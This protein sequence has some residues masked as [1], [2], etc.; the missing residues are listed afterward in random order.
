M[1]RLFLLLFGMVTFVAHAQVPDYVPTEGLVGWWPLDGHALDSGP[2]ALDGVLNGTSTVTNR[3][4]EMESA[5]SLD[6]ADD[7]VDFGYNDAWHLE[8]FTLNIWY[9]TL[10]WPQLGDYDAIVAAGDAYFMFV[11]DAGPGGGGNSS[12]YVST[13]PLQGGV[14]S[15]E[16]NSDGQW[17]MMTG[18]RN[19]SEESIELYIDGVYIGSAAASGGLLVG[20]QPLS[21]GRYWDF[22]PHWFDGNVDD[23]G[24]WNRA[25]TE[26]EILGL[27][28]APAP[29][30]G[31][32]DSTACN[33]DAEANE[34][35]GSCVYPP[36]VE[37]GDDIA[38]CEDSV[39]LD[40]GEGFTYYEWNTGDTSR[41][42]LVQEAGE[43]SVITS[44]TVP[45]EHA[46]QFNGID[47]SAQFE[48]SILFGVESFSVSVD[49]RL[50][51]FAGNDS[52]PYSYI[53]GHPLTGGTNDHGFKIQT[54]SNSLNGGFQAHI[55]DEGTTHFNVIS[56]DNSVQSNVEL[57]Q[58]YDLTMVVDRDNALFSF[59]VDGVLVEAQTIHPDFGNLDHPNGLSLGIQNIHQT[60]L[61]NGYLDNLHVWDIALNEEQVAQLQTTVPTGNEE[62]LVGFWDFEEGEGNEA[63]E[64]NGSASSILLNNVG[65]TDDGLHSMFDFSCSAE[66]SI[67]VSF[68]VSGCLNPEACNYNALAEC[69]GEA[70]EF[71]CDDLPDYVPTEGLVAWWPMDGDAVDSSP[72]E[73]H[74]QMNGLTGYANRYGVEGGALWFN[75]NGDHISVP[76]TESIGIENAFSSAVWVYLEGGSCNPRVFEIHES[77]N[78]GGYTL[79]FNGT[80]DAPR[81]IHTSNFGDCQLSL[82][83]AS[84]STAS[85]QPGEWHHIA[86]TFA[87][88]SVS[89]GKLY[90]DGIMVN[91]TS[92]EGDI[93][94]I[95][96]YGEPL[97]IGNI[98]PYRC[99]WFGGGMD[100][101]GLWEATLTDEQVWMLYSG[102]TIQFGCTDPTACNYDSEATSDDG[103]CIPS[104][105][106]E[107]LAC[108]YNALA[109][110]E[111]EA[112]NY[113]CCPGPGCCSAGMY[114]DYDL[115]QCMNYETCEDDL[116]GDGVIGVNDLMQLLSSFGTD[117][118]PAG[119]T[120]DTGGDPET[121]EWT[122]GDPVNYHGYDYA[123]VQI[124][125][126]CWFAENLR[127]EQYR[128]GDGIPHL[129]DCDS[130]SSTPAGAYCYYENEIDNTN[131]H[132]LLYNWLV[133]N[134]AN[135]ICPSEWHVPSDAEWMT[136][137]M[138]LGMS[139][140]QAN[141]TYWRGTNEGSN[142]K[143]DVNWN[144]TNTSGFQALPSG[145]R[146]P[147][148]GCG[149]AAL[150]SSTWYWTSTGNGSLAVGRQL[151][152]IESG[153]ARMTSYQLRNGFSV[154]CIKD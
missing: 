13:S 70:C 119:D 41:S 80:G 136:L 154:R 98:A 40:A 99:D 25:L 138:E 20:E 79:G 36:F 58:W 147:Y 131:L 153:I 140:S 104:G 49:C 14:W 51:A 145:T 139:E 19:A 4:N 42:I 21:I 95:D 100:E 33:Y 45:N 50:N 35:D 68:L 48:E 59:Y 112:C 144:G 103:S 18:I 85:V 5:L 113:S 123:T 52:E 126:Q 26:E 54:A 83:A 67:Q 31:C 132:G 129:I 101:L 43:Y 106:M 108:N 135:E 29:T 8:D 81:S 125:G 130:W 63:N 124:G 111:G 117:C 118:A 75:G 15:Y 55:N 1:N 34:D 87:P 61:L 66:D 12:F 134:S 143:S 109:E 6:G 17:H 92:T 69:E 57:D 141:G 88:D 28:N 97:C 11:G 37:L 30:P 110:C 60:S 86:M 72:N 77:L 102:I 62:E 82:Q 148:N 76:F 93:S 78:C 137:E 24:I 22:N 84:G 23:F 44:N 64:A 120:D 32:T 7:W 73:N 53:I 121:A 122:C 10:E 127:T 47:A 96:Y 150:D 105:C 142:V 38:T 133:T 74:G 71:D 39:F 115:E 107:P 146:G 91:E 56:F 149:F 65:W 152:S 89:L 114:W 90:I 9:S 46:L 27:Y 94:G 128:N 151:S 116:D 3:L 16:N 2:N